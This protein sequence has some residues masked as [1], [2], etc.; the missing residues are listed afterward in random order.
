MGSRGGLPHTPVFRFSMDLLELQAWLTL[1]SLPGL[2]DRTVVK[3]VQAFGSPQAVIGA[4][5]EELAANG[6]QAQLAAV[7]RRGPEPDV[8]RQIERRLAA[9]ARLKIGVVSLFDRAYPSRLRHIADPP[10]LLYVT[11]ALQERDAV[12]VAIVGGRR[13]TP[14]GRVVT[15]EIARTLAAAGVTIVSG[16]ARGID[17][18]AHRGAL[19]GRGRTIAVLGCGIDRTY[20][21]EHETLRRAIETHGAVMTELPIGAPPQSHHFPRRNRIISGLSL[22]VLVTEAASESGSLI[23]A[24][25]ALEQGREV[26]AV[27]G[28][29]REAACTGSNR[30]LK[31]G[32]TLV[33]RAEDILDDI[34]PQL[35]ARA[36]AALNIDGLPSSTTRRLGHEESLVYDALSHEARSVDTVIERTRLSAAQVASTLLSLELHGHVRQ[37]PGQQYI[38]V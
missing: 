11:G 27:P 8:H 25:L 37:L 32:A 7:I 26:F 3:L 34:L 15:E 24:K 35:D 14:T 30:L 5:D 19:S 2:G 4:S 38:R 31:E 20:P 28:S 1:Q 9:V 13:A 16:L 21:Q 23:T 18:A 33:E 12:A 36:R 17:G 6:C 29:V 10:P 22:G